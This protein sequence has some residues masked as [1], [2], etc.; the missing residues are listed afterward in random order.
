V[1]TASI[2]DRTSVYTHTGREYLF[3]V[4]VKM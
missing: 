3:G 2:G 4:R 1:P